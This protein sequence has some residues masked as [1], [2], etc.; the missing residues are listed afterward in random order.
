MQPVSKQNTDYSN[1]HSRLEKLDDELL[2][3]K[4]QQGNLEAFN[5]LYERYFA[6]VYRRVSYTVPER[7]V[8][9]VTQ[10]I[11]IAAVKSLKNFRG[12]SKFRTWMRTLIQRQIADYYRQ[13]KSVHA[14]VDIEAEHIQTNPMLQANPFGNGL[15]LD[16]RII[17]RQAMQRL[18][19]H[20]RDILLQ[21]FVDGLQFNEI[22]DA[23]SV[24]LEATKSLFRRAVTAL[25]K[26]L[27]DLSY[28]G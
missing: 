17:L 12:D 1:E 14:D 2:V 6:I 9:D 15:P 27:E 19:D 16:D 24:S 28:D 20:Y 18:P 5:V 3:Q 8:E 4:V 13:R 21:R 23:Q 25:Q 22:A 11:F 10:E 7:D 26:Q